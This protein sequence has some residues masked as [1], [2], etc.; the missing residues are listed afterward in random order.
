MAI[1]P[2]RL[3]TTLLNTHLQSKDNPLY[4]VLHDL[5]D[6]L[7]AVNAQVNSGRTNGT[8]GINGIN[9]LN[10]IP[11]PQ[12]LNG[13]DGLDGDGTFLLN[14]LP[15][16]ALNSSYFSSLNGSLVTNLTAANIT[17]SHTLPDGVL[18]TNVP[19]LNASNTFT[20]INPLITPAE[21]WIGPS[22]TAG[23]YFKGGNVGIGTTSPPSL[24]SVNGLINIKNY[25]VATLPAA[26]RG[27]IAYVTDAL[28]PTFLSTLVGGGAIVAP[29]FYNGTNWVGF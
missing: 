21:S 25:T 15:L 13:E 29:A 11:G 7:I 12:G 16:L 27:D 28:A 9:G 19:L 2:S 5:I 10:S 17:G 4:Q 14:A 23:V 1:N 20:L 3:Y 26:T 24:L 6:N 22:S 8:N 18:S